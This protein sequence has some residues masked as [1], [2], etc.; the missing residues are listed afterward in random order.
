LQ[1]DGIDADSDALMF[2]GGAISAPLNFQREDMFYTG[3]PLPSSM[4][5]TL[6][7]VGALIL[8]TVLGFY[9][10]LRQQHKRPKPSGRKSKAAPASTSLAIR[11]KK[12]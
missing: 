9:Y 7:I 8:L 2:P 1:C 4:L 6:G 10:Y 5:P 3:G 12:R 11:K